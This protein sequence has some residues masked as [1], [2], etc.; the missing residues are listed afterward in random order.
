[1]KEVC[2]W[3]C[4]PHL[5]TACFFRSMHVSLAVDELVILLANEANHLVILRA[6]RVEGCK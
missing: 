2:V 1:M 6:E 5:P 3:R 4:R